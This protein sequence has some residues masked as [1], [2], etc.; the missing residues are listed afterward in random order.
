MLMGPHAL[1]DREL[2]LPRGWAEDPD[3]PAA[4]GV[5]DEIEFATTPALA[6]EMI[7]RTTQ[8]GVPARWVTGDEVYG[9]DPGLRDRLEALGASHEHGNGVGY[10]LAIGCNRRVTV[11]GGRGGVRMP[12]D[13]IIAGLAEHCWTRYSAGAGAKGPRFYEWAFVALHPDDGPGHRWLLIRR[14]PEHGELAYYRCYSPRPVPLTELVR[15]AGVRWRIEESFPP[16]RAVD[17]ERFDPRA[18]A[19]P[20]FAGP[21]RMLVGPHVAGVHADRPLHVPDQVVL[22]DHVEDAFPGAVGGPGPQP[23]V[24]GLPRPVA[25]GQPRRP[26]AQFPQD[27]VDHLPVIAPIPAPARDGG[28]S[29]SILAQALS[30]SS[31]RPT[32]QP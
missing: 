15:G 18:G 20:F 14:H 32:T 2:Y 21:S 4:A 31:P 16:R 9:A 12:V 19:S 1:L 5:P 26:G 11:H 24:R 6:S 8:A 30:V 7:A 25:V 22:D 28:S 10:V 29:G 27:R 3:R 17:G 13:R 23:L